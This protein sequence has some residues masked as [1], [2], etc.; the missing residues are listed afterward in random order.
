M[1]KNILSKLLTPFVSITSYYCLEIFGP[2]Q[3]FKNQNWNITVS[4]TLFS[5]FVYTV[6]YSFFAFVEYIS[7]ELILSVQPF[8]NRKMQSLVIE[9]DKPKKVKVSIEINNQQFNH[10]NFLKKLEVSFPSW[11]TVMPHSTSEISPANKELTHYFV[12]LSKMDLNDTHAE[13]KFDIML[14][15]DFKSSS[16]KGKIRIRPRGLRILTFS[17]KSFVTV[18]YKSKNR[19]VD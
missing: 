7:I 5:A 17:K 1:I 2:L 15:D 8:P 3:F 16:R 6:V 12:G 19:E 9:A 18:E 4:I 11:L 10:H 13:H 14:N